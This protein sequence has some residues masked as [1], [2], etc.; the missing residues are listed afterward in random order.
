[1]IFI[2]LILSVIF[3]SVEHDIEEY[4]FF[5]VTDREIKEFV[6]KDKTQTELF[7]VDDFLSET[8]FNYIWDTYFPKPIIYGFNCVELMKSKSPI[9]LHLEGITGEDK[10]LFT[11]TL[12]Y[13]LNSIILSEFFDSN[14]MKISNAKLDVFD[15]SDKSF[16]L[17]REVKNIDNIKASFDYL[18][19]MKKIE[20]LY[21]E[22][23]IDLFR[24][25]KNIDFI[26][27]SLKSYDEK[28]SFE[29]AVKAKNEISVILIDILQNASS[30]RIPVF[31]KSRK[32]QSFENFITNMNNI[33]HSLT[34]VVKVFLNEKNKESKEEII[35]D[36]KVVVDHIKN[37]IIQ[38]D[39]FTKCV[40]TYGSYITEFKNIEA[41]VNGVFLKGN[42]DA[43]IIFDCDV[44]KIDEFVEKY[45]FIIRGYCELMCNSID[46]DIFNYSFDPENI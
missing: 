1:M 22:I 11:F 3:C 39:S 15:D 33:F 6:T 23:L 35:L 46:P 14:N 18:T 31:I 42:T 37:E 44:K 28:K 45:F 5:I 19:L 29:Q 41:F 43:E 9:S 17:S 21:N 7:K 36:E 10:V 4:G 32:L 24:Y 13:D 25:I 16:M 26:A 27:K 2:N 40:R 34:D 20:P 8:A 38:N 12:G 30:L